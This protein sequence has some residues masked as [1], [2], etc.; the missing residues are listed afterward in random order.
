ISGKLVH[1]CIEHNTTLEKLSLE[2]FRQFSDLIDEDVYDAISLQTCVNKRT[3]I[4]APA[5]ETVEA[6][7]NIVKG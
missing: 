4:G 7:L 5:P 1:Y 6:A 3:I 2:E